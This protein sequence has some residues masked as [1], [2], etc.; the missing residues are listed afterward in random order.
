MGGG[1]SMP[2][3]GHFA[4]GKDTRY[5]LYRRLGRP[6]DWSDRVRKMSP[7]PGFDSRARI[8]IP[9]TLF[10]PI[11]CPIREEKALRIGKSHYL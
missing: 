3:S 10:R 5:P 1:W 2:R 8:A 6:N 7:A 4:L 11:S 9:T